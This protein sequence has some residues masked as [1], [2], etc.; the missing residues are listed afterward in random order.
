M[1]E[2]LRC[3]IGA[4]PRQFVSLSVL[5]QSIYR[6]STKP[7]AITPLVLQQLPIKREGLTPFT[8]SRFLVPY[9]CDYKGW[10]LFLDADILLMDD[11]AKLFALKDDKYSVMVSKDPD[12]RFEW[13]SVMLFNCEKCKI[14]TPEYIETATGLHTITWAQDSE[15]GDLPR[16]WNHLIGYSPEPTVVPSLL[17]YTQAMPAYPLTQDSPYALEWAKE[18]QLMNSI[19]SWEE[20]MGNSIHAMDLDGKR[21]PKYKAKLNAQNASSATQVSTG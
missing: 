20:L 13:A 21:V 4:D 14:L 16:S 7:V 12:H 3:F 1:T 17:H 19:R 9:L 2:I 11:I 5:A 10:A 18:H 8:F 15:I 6:Q